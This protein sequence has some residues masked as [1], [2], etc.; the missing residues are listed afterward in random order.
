MNVNVLPSEAHVQ[1]GD[2]SRIWA[3]I[4]PRSQEMLDSGVHG[5]DHFIRLRPGGGFAERFVVPGS[6]GTL[7]MPGSEGAFLVPGSKT[8]GGF[9]LCTNNPVWPMR[10]AK[11]AIALITPPN[12]VN[13]PGRVCH[14]DWRPGSSVIV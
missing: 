2:A 4:S 1:F 8:G 3:D 9:S 12:A 10:P 6:K 11:L 5:W 13:I 14:H 7:L